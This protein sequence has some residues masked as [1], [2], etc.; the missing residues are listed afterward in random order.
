MLVGFSCLILFSYFYRGMK[1]Q[2][3][4]KALN[5]AFLTTTHKDSN[6]LAIYNTKEMLWQHFNNF[7]QQLTAS[8]NKAFALKGNFSSCF[9]F[10]S[11][12][13]SK[14]STDTTW[15][16]GRL[17]VSLRKG[18]SWNSV[19]VIKLPLF[20]NLIEK[21]VYCR[22]ALLNKLN[23]LRV[24]LWTPSNGCL[25]NDIFLFQNQI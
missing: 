24:F 3:K 25:W 5:Y 16:K 13:A 1:T 6:S 15:T 21:E 18:L 8:D 4:R 23:F 19:V 9:P 12:E 10:N 22:R 2:R 11:T 14:S 20:C 7:H 17:Q